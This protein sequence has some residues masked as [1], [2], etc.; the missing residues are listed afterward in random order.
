MF[1]EILHGCFQSALNVAILVFSPLA[2]NLSIGQLIY[3]EIL[4]IH[5]FT[6]LFFQPSGIGKKPDRKEFLDELFAFLESKGNYVSV[7]HIYY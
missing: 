1:L 7:F 4:N 6:I 2:Y 5:F 3:V